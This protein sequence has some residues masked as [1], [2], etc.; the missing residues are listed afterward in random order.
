[1]FLNLS[2]EDLDQNIYRIFS[3]A[4]LQELFD[5]EK[6][7]LVKPHKWEDPFENFILRSKVKLPS[8][9]ITEYNFHDRFY[10]QCWTFHK[11]SDAMWRIY[12]P[13]SDGVRVRTTVRK[14]LTGLYLTQNSLPDV[15]CCLGK[16]LYL[17]Q[18]KLKE[19]AN[20]IFD[21]YG[22][23]VENLFKSLL[24]KRPAF[25]HEKEIR[26]LYFELE[27]EGFKNDTFAYSIDPHSLITQIMIDPRIDYNKAKELKKSI[28]QR[29]QFQGEIKR[30][31][32]Y[33][34]PKDMVLTAKKLNLVTK[35]GK[36]ANN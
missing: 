11:A 34:F 10:G 25:N 9:E 14:L 5:T 31:L 23:T 20:N 32:L 26:L 24:V 12:S 19:Y 22:I 36:P 17:N 27:D 6:N 2:E 4:R 8:G 3:L 18:N 28:R 16:V 21:D 15:K 7:V 29:T 33:S 30:S 35:K 1:M 13:S